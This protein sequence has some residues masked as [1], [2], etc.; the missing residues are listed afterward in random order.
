MMVTLFGRRINSVMEKRLNK[1]LRP[2]D[3]QI[4]TFLKN[5][6]DQ[7]KKLAVGTYDYDVNHTTGTFTNA[8]V[9]TT[10][11]TITKAAHGFSTGDVLVLSSAGTL[12]TGFS[13][14]TA[15][16]VIYV[17]SSTFKLA[18]SRANAFA[19]TNIDITAKTGAA[20][21][22]H[23]YHKG[24]F[25]AVSLLG[26]NVKIPDTAI[27]TRTYYK[28]YTTFTST[29]TDNATIALSLN[30]A[31]DIVTATAIKTAGDIWDAA[32]VIA[33]A[34]DNAVGN[35]LVLTADRELLMTIGTDTLTAGKLKLFVEY[36]DTAAAV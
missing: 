34:Q 35:M 24:I 27:I 36:I 14:A 10:A 3:Y 29:T 26:N 12:P 23:T 31:N 8:A 19:G 21:V 16:Y 30:G 15:Y 11:D 33:G 9:S 22:V 25:G 13:T 32:G 7:R 17:N 6:Q 20:D 4:G 18:S 1:I 2:V 28:V 5:N